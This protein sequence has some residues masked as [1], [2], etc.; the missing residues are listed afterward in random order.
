MNNISATMRRTWAE[1]CLD[2]LTYNYNTIRSCVA[3]NTMMCCV[4]KANAYGHGAVELARLY[5]QLGADF[6]A[7]SNIEE[8]IQLRR[9]NIDLPILILGYAPAE[10]AKM[11]S[12]LNIS[13]CVYSLEYANELAGYAKKFNVKIKI[14]IKIDTGMGRIGFVHSN[15]SQSDIRDILL[16]K[17]MNCFNFEGIFTH[18][19]VADKGENGR[20]YTLQ[21]YK[22]FV[23]AVDFLETR[24]MNFKIKHCANSASLLDYPQMRFD[25]VRAGIILYGLEPSE[26]IQRS[27][28]LKHAMTLKSIISNIKNISAGDA[29]GYGR[30][31]VADSSR[32][33]ATLPIGYADGLL[34]CSTGYCV[35]VSNT[36]APIV[37]NVCMDQLMVDV[38]GIDCNVNDTVTIFGP[39][40]GHT[41]DDMAIHNNT[42]NYEIVCNISDRVPRAY[43]KNNQI[44]HWH[45]GLCQ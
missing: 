42:I 31:Y 1:I 18:F 43:I 4:I 29:V 15:K 37:G 10:C 38:T 2:S 36:L 21:Q 33:I 3:D 25:M 26:Q 35:L 12:E 17:S 13:Q 11:L 6:L 40:C 24:G 8:A 14:H 45:S 30:S 20:D 23:S 34:R 44:V 5:K 41:A 19:S 7:V 28:S 32:R 39:I 9:N 16:L 22:N 27:I